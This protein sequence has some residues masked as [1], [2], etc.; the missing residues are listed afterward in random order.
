[1][2]TTIFTYHFG[3]TT[4]FY[5]Q[6]SFDLIQPGHFGI[7][8]CQSLCLNRYSIAY[9]QEGRVPGTPR[10]N[11]EG[12]LDGEWEKCEVDERPWKPFSRDVAVERLGYGE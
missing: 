9:S 7:I 4:M 5:T 12:V 11:G 3:N 1:M 2:S 10:K 8:E 6:V